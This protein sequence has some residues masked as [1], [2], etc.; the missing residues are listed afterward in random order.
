MTGVDMLVNDR[1]PRRRREVEN[2]QQ[3]EEDHGA[4]PNGTPTPRP[5]ALD[6]RFAQAPVVPEESRDYPKWGG[7]GI[8]VCEPWHDPARFFADIERLIGPKPPGMSLDRRDNN[9]HYEEGNVRWAPPV[10]QSRNN[11]NAKLNKNK[12]RLIKELVALGVLKGALAE[13]A[14]ISRRQLTRVLS[15]KSWGDV[16]E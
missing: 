5:W 2:Q 10:V 4:C 3:G 15:G 13:V 11:R 1:T 16:S 9:G 12:V 14:G 8:E 6:P 7:R